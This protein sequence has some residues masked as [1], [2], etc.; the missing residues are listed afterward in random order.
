MYTYYILLC[1][2]LIHVHK[3]YI[4]LA[5]VYICTI[6][7]MQATCVANLVYLLPH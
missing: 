3:A 2:Y 1:T 5:T 6:A 7:Q 4:Y